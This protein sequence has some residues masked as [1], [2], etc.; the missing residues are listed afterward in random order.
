MSLQLTPYLIPS[1]AAVEILVLSALYVWWCRPRL[2][3]SATAVVLLLA[4]AEWMFC[5]ALGHAGDTLPAKVLWDK[6]QYV[7]I[8]IVPTAWLVYTLQYADRT[9]WLRRKAFALLSIAPLGTV[10][11][12]FTNEVH[13]L[14]WKHVALDATGPF[15]VLNKTYGL[16]FWIFVIY[17]YSLLSL[18]CLLLVEML[19]R[20]PRLYA[21]QATALLLAT[22]GPWTLSALDV[23]NLNPFP[24]F[25]PTAVGLAVTGP[26]L[27]WTLRRIRLGEV[28]PVA[29]EATLQAMRD[30][31]I[32]LDGA[33]RVVDLNSVGERLI[34]KSLA[35]TLAQR[36]DE[37]WLDLSEQL[38]RSTNSTTRTAE[39]MVTS[40]HDRLVYDVS[41]SQIADWRGHITSRVVVL[42]D[43]TDRKLA[44]QALRQSEAKYRDLVEN[45][46]DVIYTLD[47]SGTVTY[48]SPAIESLIG[49][50]PLEVIGHP[51]D[52]FIHPADLQRIS[53]SYDHILSGHRPATAEYRVL[54]KSGQTRWMRT[55][56]RP[57][58]V[59]GRV[60]G[61]RGV[62]M[63]ITELKRTEQA[64]RE[65]EER[66]RSLFRDT[67]D[68]IN[69]T[70]REGR[71][72]DANQSFLHL[73]GYT[74]EEMAT[75]NATE[76]YADPADRPKFQEEIER[77]G[78]VRDYEVRLRKKD[79]TEMDCL[80]TSVV[81]RS[82]DGN[83]VGYQ[84]FIH[85]VTERKRAEET[86]RRL[87]YYDSLTGLPNRTL[88]NDRL[89]LALARARRNHQK[90]AIM[91]LDLDNF[92]D[93][94]DTLGHPVGDTLLE[95][96][97][98]RLQGLL[99]ASDTVARMGGDEFLLLLPGLAQAQ[100][101]EK[102][103]DKILRAI[104]KPL[105]LDG[106]PLH[107]TTSVG[108]AVFPDDGEDGD[109][110][111]KNADIAM[112]RAKA[113][114]RDCYRLYSPPESDQ[115]GS[116]TKSVKHATE[117]KEHKA[118][119]HA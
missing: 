45:V 14:I 65:S 1:L 113:A 115:I 86:I 25:D 109:T 111:V 42:H 102:L 26:I 92:K 38:E 94:N 46:S 76:V 20:S 58:T 56:S 117:A 59:D 32:V 12:V 15:A 35:D 108:I 36:I 98:D 17:A 40:G 8:V 104:R 118:E 19:V 5:A 18:A 70:T 74:R 2:P 82:E 103:A 89:H 54:S 67:R 77:E 81:R 37:V 49:Y 80:V 24:Q 90:L 30:G 73:F 50:S 4:A 39:V 22:L 62:L 13:G 72:I 66:Y 78:S 33:N 88:F 47:C 52:E 105:V 28:V 63:D 95:Q 93:V 29:R 106:H 16:G 75:L 48:V 9:K 85:D 23:M 64:L 55:S 6:L 41:L 57:I 116:H 11:L 7:G 110:L 10:L 87:A 43:I 84:G 107:V 60:A 68:A 112:Y 31:V 27:A 21:W 101:A 97:G 83:V 53:E 51:F 79:G 91:L 71:I 100:D 3:G 44:E 69:I 114:G 61:L 34:G 96:V 99:R 119:L